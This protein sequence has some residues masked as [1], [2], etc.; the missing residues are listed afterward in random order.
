ME[1]EIHLVCIATNGWIDSMILPC[2]FVPVIAEQ[3]KTAAEGTNTEE[4]AKV[5][6]LAV[7]KRRGW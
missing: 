3:I 5:A 2:D 7:G 6:A 1:L 4:Y